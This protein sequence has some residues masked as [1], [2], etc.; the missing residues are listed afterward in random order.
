MTF[1]FTRIAQ[2]VREVARS[3]KRVARS[4]KKDRFTDNDF[5][6]AGKDKVSLFTRAYVCAAVCSSQVRDRA[7]RGSIFRMCQRLIY[8]WNRC[9]SQNKSVGLLADI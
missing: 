5:K 1:Y 8:R 4:E 2:L 9:Q 7:P 3:N 6:F